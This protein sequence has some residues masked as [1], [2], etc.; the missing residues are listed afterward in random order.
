MKKRASN[1]KSNVKNLLNEFRKKLLNLSIQ[2]RLNFTFLYVGVIALFIVIIGLINMIKIDSSLNQFY[3]GPYKIEDN[4]LNAQVSMERIENNIY[5]AYFTKKE[6]LCKKYIE[7]SEEEYIR[8][9][10]NLANLSEAITM[11]NIEMI[12]KVEKLK[13][14]ID[15]G[16]RYR[17]QILESAKTFDQE[18]I[19]SIYK[20]DY[21]PI[22]EHILTI[23]DEIEVSSVSYGQDYIKNAN[24][25]VTE[26]IVAFLSLI[27]LGS[28]SCIYLLIKTANSITRPINE[29]KK[30][31]LYLAKGD[32][33]IDIHYDSQDEMGVL[34]DAVRETSMKLKKYIFNIT[35]VVK[36]LEDKNMTVRVDVD[37]EGDFRPIK[38]SIDNTVISFQSMLS[39]I[40]DTAEQITKGAEQIAQTSRT[41]ADGGTEQSNALSVLVNEINDIVSAVNKNAENAL[42]IN[43]LSQNTVVAAKQG[44]NQMLSLVHAMEA[45][46]IHSKN[47]SK[48]IHVIEEISEQTNLLSLNAT[49]EAARAG[50]AGKGFGVVASEIGKLA[51]E[52]AKAVKSTAE[53]IHNTTEA[54][55]E[56]VSMANDTANN[57]ENIVV[58]TMKTN[59]FMANMSID[60]NKQA[61]QLKQSLSYLQQI[62]NIIETNLAAAEESSAMSEEFISQAEN[63]ESLLSTYKLT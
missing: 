52:C 22:L 34:C 42:G 12:E 15:K 8:L 11:L 3:K 50:N 53:L 47:V 18:R 54:I 9:E 63:L 6:D 7:A 36:Q 48:V 33:E 26:S 23:L 25:K 5:R 59:Q 24:I 35:S 44:N 45:I 13:L 19:Y 20:N 32:L 31:M 38:E 10:Q 17:S 49:I 30:S 4:V 62:S 58:E 57:F 60:S 27:L 39:T 16:N 55:K 56:G 14:E 51:N 1:N 29:I 37:Y 2:K 61:E 28:L 40:N 46:A 41:V 43:R 21:V